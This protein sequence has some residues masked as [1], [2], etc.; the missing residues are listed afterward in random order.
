MKT[1]NKEEKKQHALTEAQAIAAGITEEQA[2]LAAPIVPEG[3]QCI[4]DYVEA[5]KRNMGEPDFD[6]L[7]RL[8]FGADL[9]TPNGKTL[10]GEAPK[11]AETDPIG[12]NPAKAKKTTKAKAKKSKPTAAQKK[13][14]ET[15]LDEYNRALLKVEAG[16]A[17]TK[18][19]TWQTLYKSLKDQSATAHIEW[20][21]CD[22]A[23][24]I[25]R[26]Q[27][28]VR[29]IDHLLPA[30]MQRLCATLKQFQTETDSLNLSGLDFTPASA[31]FNLETGQIEII[32]GEKISKAV[33][34]ELAKKMPDEGKTGDPG[35][36][37]QAV[38]K[39]KKEEKPVKE[40]ASAPESPI[41][42]N[43]GL[44]VDLS[45]EGIAPPAEPEI[46]PPPVEEPEPE[47]VV[48]IAPEMTMAESWRIFEKNREGV[49]RADLEDLWRKAI[50][51]L[52]VGYENMT[53]VDW[54]IISATPITA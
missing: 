21:E 19:E 40:S 47:N 33:K 6:D 14:K 53:P 4:P 7:G 37:P 42:E 23:K 35:E 34:K 38:T 50:T 28:T 9:I 12:K 2:R 43:G 32:P 10:Q 54:A 25:K 15:Q 11:A 3:T 22:D 17:V 20:V 31:S 48:P 18:T 16:A 36:A 30:P 51:T 39:E 49:S 8:I 27:A 46:V 24:E 52:G 41:T 1:S 13:K 29:V 45:P 44:K 5:Y 26:L